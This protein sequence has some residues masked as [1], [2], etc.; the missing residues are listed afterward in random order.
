MSNINWTEDLNI[1]IDSI[2]EQHRHIIDLFNELNEAH[3][4]GEI[5]V[6]NKTLSELVE[7]KAFHCA[8]EEDLLKQSGFP[9]YKMHKLSHE[10]MLNKFSALGNRAK[11]GEFVINES[12]PLLRA[13]LVNHIKGEDADYANYLRQSQRGG[14]IEERGIFSSLKRV[15]G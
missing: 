15:F 6:A 2:D 11:N 12:V 5:H 4:C 13:A 14:Q 1:G 10:L 9:L 8:H 3:T 7:F